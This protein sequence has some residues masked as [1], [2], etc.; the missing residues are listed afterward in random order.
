MASLKLGYAKQIFGLGV[1]SCADFLTLVY[2]KVKIPENNISYVSSLTTMW[3]KRA[4]LVI[5]DGIKVMTRFADKINNKQVVV[6]SDVPVLLRTLKFIDA[7]DYE[8]QTSFCF[9]FK[10]VN[11]Q[12]VRTA[13]SR[14]GGEVEV[15]IRNTNQ[16]GYVIDS[17]KKTDPLV[18]LL[19]ATM[20]SID[21][22]G[23]G[24]IYG[25]F[26]DMCAQDKF[27]STKFVAAINST[28][29]NFNSEEITAFLAQFKK[30]GKDYYKAIRSDLDTKE[31]AEEYD[32]DPYGV[33]FFRK[34]IRSLDIATNRAKRSAA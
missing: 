16:L 27:N 26:R 21:F 4:T 11:I 6:V 14:A 18:S 20:A 25:A 3:P 1:T 24:K 34:K 5:V 30:S 7:I 19:V 17:Q 8:M 9:M 28:K 15:R 22:A 31:A 32:V 12:A 2:K 23:R 10:P 33:A 13:L 29:S